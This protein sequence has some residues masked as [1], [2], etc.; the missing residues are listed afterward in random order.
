MIG[1]QL[2]VCCAGRLILAGKAKCAGAAALSEM[3][4]ERCVGRLR[5]LASW[6]RQELGTCRPI[7]RTDFA[8]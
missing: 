6:R 1:S 2:I 4:D 8:S 7:A 3:R 5:N